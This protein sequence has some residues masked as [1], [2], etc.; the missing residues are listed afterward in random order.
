LQCVAVCCSVLQCVAVCCSVSQCVAVCRSVLQCVAVC[1]SVLLLFITRISPRPHNRGVPCP[2]KYT[3]L[4]IH[5]KRQMWNQ[6]RPIKEFSL[7]HVSHQDRTTEGCP[8]LKNTLLYKYTERDQCDTKRDL[9]KRPRKE[10]HWL[11]K[12]AM[13]LPICVKHHLI[14]VKRR[15]ICVKRLSIF[16][17]SHFICVKSLLVCVKSLSICVICLFIHR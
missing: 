13:Y 10:T 3:A 9:E 14:C 1:C 12:C 7:S 11:S 5:W 2:Q 15:F 16:V 8:A 4:H 17:K 6:K